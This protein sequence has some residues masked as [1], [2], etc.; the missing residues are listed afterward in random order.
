M[1]GL[2]VG[3]E[4]NAQKTLSGILTIIMARVKTVG[5]NYVM[6]LTPFAT[7]VGKTAQIHSWWYDEIARI[8]QAQRNT[9]PPRGYI[10]V[11]NDLFPQLFSWLTMGIGQSQR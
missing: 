10:S 5:I 9:Q 6:F 4:Y 7:N 2:I 8:D 11:V 1:T 3:A